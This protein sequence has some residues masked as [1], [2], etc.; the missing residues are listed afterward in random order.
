MSCTPQAVIAEVMSRLFPRERG[1]EPRK[2]TR[3]T[4]TDGPMIYLGQQIV[5]HMQDAGYPSKI[6]FGYRPPEVQAELY[7]KGRT[8]PG[9]IVT[10]APPWSS[11]HQYY[12]A[13]DIVH[14]S[15][16]WEV[17]ED[18][19]ETLAACVEVVSENYGVALTHGHTWAFRDSAHIQMGDWHRVKDRKS[20]V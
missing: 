12:E 17:S 7:A 19:W 8:E 4:Y 5:R 6:I 11:P 1:Q 2:Q 18:Y 10:K 20:V 3:Y 14:K 16:G 13:V 9:T 15:K